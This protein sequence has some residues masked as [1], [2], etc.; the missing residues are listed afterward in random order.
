MLLLVAHVENPFGDEICNIYYQYT[1]FSRTNQV[2]D[3]EIRAA[4]RKMR[5]CDAVLHGKPFLIF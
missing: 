3:G 4:L 2:G 1:N 5:P